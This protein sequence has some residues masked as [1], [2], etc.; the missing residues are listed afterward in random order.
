MITKLKKVLYTVDALHPD[1]VVVV[2]SLDE[3]SVLAA[4]IALYRAACVIARVKREQEQ[5]RRIVPAGV[6]RSAKSLVDLAKP[7]IKMVTT[8]DWRIKTLREL[9]EAEKEAEASVRVSDLRPL[10]E[11][12]TKSLLNIDPYCKLIIGRKGIECACELGKLAIPAQSTKPGRIGLNIRYLIDAVSNLIARKIVSV[13]VVRRQG[14]DILVLSS[15]H[16]RHYI[17]EMRQG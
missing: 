5:V 8:D 17:V 2:Q 4:S 6:L 1:A 14:T 11:L 3:S 12:R 16:E 9:E 10:K 7:E 13:E 15:E